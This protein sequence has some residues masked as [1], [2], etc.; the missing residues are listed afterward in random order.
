[1]SPVQLD[2]TGEVGC[3][4]GLSRGNGKLASQG[5]LGCSVLVQPQE[6]H[7]TSLS[8][9]FFVYEMGIIIAHRVKGELPTRVPGAQQMVKK[10]KAKKKRQPPLPLLFLTSFRETWDRTS[11][12]GVSWCTSPLR[13]PAIK[14]QWVCLPLRGCASPPPPH[15][16]TLQGS[17]LQ[18]AEDRTSWNWRRKWGMEGE[19]WEEE[20]KESSRK[21]RGWRV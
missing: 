3:R 2:E 9:S 14:E 18:Q 21:G 1:M 20:I 7:L 4:K 8:L 15:T 13:A 16:Y 5:S 11:F 12:K 19:I 17:N 6:I 10:K